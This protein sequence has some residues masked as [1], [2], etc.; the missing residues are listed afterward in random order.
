MKESNR[1][2]VTFFGQFPIIGCQTRQRN[3]F[4]SDKRLSFK[5]SHNRHRWCF[6]NGDCYWLRD[7]C[8]KSVGGAKRRF[9]KSIG[10]VSVRNVRTKCLISITKIPNILDIVSLSIFGQPCKIDNQRRQPLVDVRRSF[11]DFWSQISRD[12]LAQLAGKK[13]EVQQLAA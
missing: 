7:G 8:L 6:A 9:I 10:C 4:A 3:C 5:R 11:N 13:V 2:T 12:K 1:P